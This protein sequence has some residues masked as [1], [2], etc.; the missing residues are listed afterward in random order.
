MLMKF[1]KRKYTKFIDKLQK[2]KNV[3]KGL[4]VILLNNQYIHMICPFKLYYY[5]TNTNYL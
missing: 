2:P 3:Y 1:M 5:N 4:F